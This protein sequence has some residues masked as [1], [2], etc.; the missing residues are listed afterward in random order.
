[1]TKDK[2]RKYSESNKNS[3]FKI[4][5]QAALFIVF[6]LLFFIFFFKKLHDFILL[7]YK[8]A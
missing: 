8:H 1:M 2:L 3:I 7:K 6:L 4:V 5:Q